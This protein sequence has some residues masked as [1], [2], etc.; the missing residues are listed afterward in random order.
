MAV[1]RSNIPSAGR[2]DGGNNVEEFKDGDFRRD[3]HVAND[4]KISNLKIS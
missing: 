3:V 1:V 4:P 2:K